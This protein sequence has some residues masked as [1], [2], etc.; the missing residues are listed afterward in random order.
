MRN[1]AKSATV[2]IC[3]CAALVTPWLAASAHGESRPGAAQEPGLRIVVIEGAD[4][5]NII[6]QGTPEPTVVEVRDRSDF[7]VAGASVLF[8]LREGGIATLDA[9]SLQ[10]TAT[11]NALG[12]AEVTVNPL[13]SGTVELSVTATFQGLT[14]STTIVQTNAAARWAGH[15][16]ARRHRGRGGG[17]GARYPAGARRVPTVGPGASDGDSRRPAA[18]GELDRAVG[19]RGAD[20]RLRRAV[21][22]VRR[23]M[24]GVVGRRREHE[25]PGHDRGP[26]ERDAV[27]GASTGAELGGREPVVSGRDGNADRGALS[28]GGSDGDSR[29]PAAGGELDRAVGQ[30]GADRATTTCAIGRCRTAFGRSCRT[31]GG[32]RARARRSEA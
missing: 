13:A 11:T 20:R 27:R 14:A 24:D 32:T 12:Q 9:G 28:A 16:C 18:G 3:T 25:H 21:S 7:P 30:R 26:D 23:R 5:V 17:D 4:S 15:R 31:T 19:Q 10:V 2:W 22:V 1:E 8:L 29:R 6:G